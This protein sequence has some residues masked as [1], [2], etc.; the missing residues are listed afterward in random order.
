MEAKRVTLFGK[1]LESRRPKAIVIDVDP[2]LGDAPLYGL[3]GQHVLLE[4]QCLEV[5][6]G[7]PGRDIVII[8]DHIARS[9]VK[10]KRRRR[11]E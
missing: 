10:P 3:A 4:R 9:L 8:P 6:S 11:E 7:P 5:R 2:Q 1:I